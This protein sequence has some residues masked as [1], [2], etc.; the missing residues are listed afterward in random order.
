MTF[1]LC[2]VTPHPPSSKHTLEA[3]RVQ[4][5]EYICIA[6]SEENV[7]HTMPHTHIEPPWPLTSSPHPDAPHAPQRSWGIIPQRWTAGPL[8][9][10]ELD[11]HLFL[12]QDF[13]LKK[14]VQHSCCQNNTQR[15]WLQQ[16]PP[17]DQ[18]IHCSRRAA[19]VFPLIVG[20]WIEVN[21]TLTHPLY[22]YTRHF[23]DSELQDQSWAVLM[24]A[25]FK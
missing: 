24:S 15:R 3:L 2:P 18:R 23:T 9:S 13:S 6:F 17:T 10:E 4:L 14:S 20:I 5:S 7:D 21:Q 19:L 25:G 22:T 11:I 16:P 1:N 12:V 8:F